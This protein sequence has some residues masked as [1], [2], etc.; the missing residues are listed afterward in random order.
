[1]QKAGEVV[2]LHPS[3]KWVTS[4]CGGCGGMALCIFYVTEAV[5]I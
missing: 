1:M 5:W 4:L 3:R 2:L